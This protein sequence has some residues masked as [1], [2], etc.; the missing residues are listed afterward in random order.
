MRVRHGPHYETDDA[1]FPAE[2]YTC[3]SYPG[4]ACYVLGW[5]TEPDE[6]TA[7]TGYE[8]RTGSVVLV[9]VGDDHHFTADPEDVTPLDRSAYCGQCGQVGCSHDGYDREGK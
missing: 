2:A 5:E 9:M 7:W 4:V 6:D 8:N 3:R 1:A